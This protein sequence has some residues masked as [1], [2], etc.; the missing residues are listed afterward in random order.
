[1]ARAWAI[2]FTVRNTAKGEWNSRPL[3]GGDSGGNEVVELCFIDF[4]QCVRVR[5][6]GEASFAGGDEFLGRPNVVG[7]GIG[8][9]GGPVC[10]LGF[11]YCLKVAKPR[12]PSEGERFL[13][14][15]LPRSPG[16]SGV[17][18]P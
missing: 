6:G 8:Q 3:W 4:N 1:M 13:H 17:F 5:E 10:L 14:A 7:G 18:S 12:L 2:S 16:G 9:E 15:V 11:L